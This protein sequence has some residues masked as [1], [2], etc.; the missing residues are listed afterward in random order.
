MNN[1]V[2]NIKDKYECTVRICNVVKYH[3]V[4]KV[5]T[6]KQWRMACTYSN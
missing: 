5:K 4:Y 6:D 2:V 3:I 1:G